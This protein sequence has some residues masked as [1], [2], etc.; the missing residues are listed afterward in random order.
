MKKHK[1][2]IDI[3]KCKGCM[4][5]V[6]FCPVKKIYAGDAVGKRG[7]KY[8]VLNDMECSGCGFCF[9]MCPD[10]AIEIEEIGDLLSQIK[11]KGEEVRK[12]FL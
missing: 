3:E 10:N 8:A 1:V 5:C 6:R 2:T 4:L 11:E 7:S 12:R 9:L